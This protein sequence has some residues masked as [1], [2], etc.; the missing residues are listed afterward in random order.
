MRPLGPSPMT[1]STSEWFERAG[2]AFVS[3]P[4]E[5]RERLSHIRAF[6][7]DW[8]GVF[9]A[10]TK[11]EGVF[12]SWSEADSMGLNLLRFGFWLRDGRL[13]PIV[14]MTGQNNPSAVK[15][16]SRE[17]FQAVYQGFL[18]KDVALDHLLETFGLAESEVAFLFDDA[19]DLSVARRVGLRVLVRRPASPL[20]QR[21]V[22]TEGACDY[23]TA[24][25]GGHHAVRETAELIL[26]LA[27]LYESVVGERSSFSDRYARYFGE[28]QAQSVRRF[29]AADGGVRETPA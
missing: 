21:H 1:L 13:P 5:I 3:T 20:F 7:L 4:D 28:R 22:L 17:H 6:V 29:E 2:G 25:E 27:G 9:N 14:I 11:G 10:G 16:S 24:M 23:V 26:G 12:S 8:D 15:L 19:L 18:A